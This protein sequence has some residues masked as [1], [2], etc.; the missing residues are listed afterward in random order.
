MNTKLRLQNNTWKK[1]GRTLKRHWRNGKTKC[2]KGLLN[3]KIHSGWTV[4]DILLTFYEVEIDQYLLVA[5]WTMWISMLQGH[6]CFDNLCSEPQMSDRHLYRPFLFHW[7]SVVCY[8]YS[9][10]GWD[11]YRSWQ[12]CF[13]DFLGNVAS[14]LQGHLC[15]DN[16]C[17]ETQ[18]WNEHLYSP[19]L[20]LK[21]GSVSYFSAF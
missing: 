9:I 21:S 14:K 18:M 15:F 7:F 17:L 13:T 16:P 2:G 5:F 19:F 8:L 4:F 10:W 6:L 12:G 3:D 20:V 11:K 1:K